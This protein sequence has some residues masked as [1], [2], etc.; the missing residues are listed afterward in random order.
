MYLIKLKLN[1]YKIT[2]FKINLNF[3][4]IQSFYFDFRIC[5]DNIH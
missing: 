3:K 1:K 4:L 5:L 2:Y